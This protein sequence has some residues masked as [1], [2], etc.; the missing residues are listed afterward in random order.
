MDLE[1]TVAEFEKNKCFNCYLKGEHINK[2]FT[3]E[4]TQVE[5]D[6]IEKKIKESEVLFGFRETE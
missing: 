2:L 3:I 6:T 1:S 5:Y 4:N